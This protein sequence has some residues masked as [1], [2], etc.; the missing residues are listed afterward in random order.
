MHRTPRDIASV[1]LAFYVFSI[2]WA[3][4]VDAIDSG[5]CYTK[6][7][8]IFMPVPVDRFKVGGSLARFILG[9]KII[10]DTTASSALFHL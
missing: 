4:V 10:L 2:L 3:P 7:R 8:L 6:G 9:R 5:G 1:F